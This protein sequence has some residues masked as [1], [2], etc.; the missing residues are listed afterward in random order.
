M[1]LAPVVVAA[2]VLTVTVVAM[3]AAVLAVAMV[4]TVVPVMVQIDT[5][6]PR[7]EMPTKLPDPPVRCQ[8]VRYAPRPSGD[9]G[10]LLRPWPVCASWIASAGLGGQ[11]RLWD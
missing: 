9:G 2:V 4:T 6:V 8:R 5:V 1:I 3:V 10:S 7:T 11:G